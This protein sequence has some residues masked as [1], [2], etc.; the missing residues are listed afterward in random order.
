M[1]TSLMP[2]P[3]SPRCASSSRSSPIFRR[4]SLVSRGISSSSSDA[5]EGSGASE[6]AAR[7]N[8]ARHGSQD[9]RRPSRCGYLTMTS[10]CPLPMIPS[11]RARPVARVRDA[12]VV[13]GAAHAPRSP[14]EDHRRSAAATR[15][16]PLAAPRPILCPSFQRRPP[17][18]K[19]GARLISPTGNYFSALRVP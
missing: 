8:G 19:T 2:A 1:S 16:A 9:A 10:R 6:D 14:P 17:R 7:A 18:V 11:P 12:P 5:A 3:S 13:P 4:F 15:C